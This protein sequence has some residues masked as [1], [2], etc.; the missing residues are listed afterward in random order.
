MVSL[1]HH[2]YFWSMIRMAQVLA[3]VR[4]GSCEVVSV[5]SVDACVELVIVS[6]N[7]VADSTACY[8]SLLL[9]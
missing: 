5:T 4:S 2:S 6:S 3:T 1:A 9:N 7:Y 8:F